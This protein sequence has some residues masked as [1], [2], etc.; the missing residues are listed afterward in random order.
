LSTSEVAIRVLT[1][2]SSQNW[3]REQSEKWNKDLRFILRKIRV[4]T[5]LLRHPAVPRHAKLVATCTLG[6]L[7]SPIQ[8]IPSFIPIIG[9]LDDL[10][11][12]LTG[13][14]LLRSLAPTPALAECVSRADS[15]AS[16]GK[17]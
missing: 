11:V 3:L 10:A 7:V 17:M 5:L 4:I 9:Q 13:I 16:A 12:L 8:I 14:K 15:T 1:L 6:Y 2:A